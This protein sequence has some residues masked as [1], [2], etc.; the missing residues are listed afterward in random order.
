MSYD[1]ISM[2]Y[3]WLQ[4]NSSTVKTTFEDASSDAIM[5]DRILL[6][7]LKIMELM[8]PIATKNVEIVYFAVTVCQETGKFGTI[9]LYFIWHKNI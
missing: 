1:E 5:F 4:T 6:L 2:E 3:N 8:L 7:M 9:T